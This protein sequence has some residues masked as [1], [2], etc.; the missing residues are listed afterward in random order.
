[1]KT[2]NTTIS[3]NR[4]ILSTLV[5]SVLIAFV[6]SKLFSANFISWDDGIVLLNNKDVHRFDLTAFFSRY[7]VGNYAPLSM[8]SF[9][10][11]WLIFKGNPM[12]HHA[13]SLLFHIVNSFLVF[14]F[15]NL[16][17][18][19]PLKAI[20]CA[21]VFCFHPLQVETVA[22]VSAKNNLV[23][24]LFFLLGVFYYTKFVIDNKQKYYFYT[25]LFFLLAVLSKPS[26]I[27]FP[28]LLI[29]MDYLLKTKPN[30]KSVLKNKIPFIIVAVTFGIV[31]IYTRTEDQ[32]INQN[33]DYNIHERIG[34]AGYAIS[35]YLYKFFLPI[36][37]SVIY[38]YP[39]NKLLS[40][41]I[42]YIS[43]ALF[44][45]GCFKLYKSSHKSVVFGLLFFVTNLLLVLQFIPFGEVLTADRYMYLP[46]IG[47]TFS[48]V[49]IFP[50]RKK[51]L[52]I[53]AFVLILI[54]GTLTFK[55]VNVWQNSTTLYSDILEKYPHSHIALN[56]LGAEYMVNKNY[57]KAMRLLNA[58]IYENKTYHKSYYNRGLLFAQT[59]RMLEALKDFNIA[60]ELKQYPKAYV[61]R[62]NAY[63]ELKDLPKAKRDAEFIL[64]I[65][66]NNP[67]ATFVLANCYSDLN[68]LDKAISLYTKSIAMND[69]EPSFYFKRAIALGKQQKFTECLNDLNACTN[70]NPNF[71][72]AYYWKGVAKVILK[73]NP[74]SD[75]EKALTLGYVVARD[76]YSK[77]CK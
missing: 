40:L 50:V 3:N 58:S 63:Y 10:I 47:L 7:Y 27:C 60:I 69:E 8:I 46:I 26:A 13:M 37:L 49:S 12:G 31:T 33:H 25:L 35:Q 28:L 55:R 72:E 29:L 67:N 75:L 1:M 24:S 23:Y 32:F 66:S 73:Q 36:N 62:A 17:L 64:S 48:L 71:A 59:G 68:Q 76:S 61:A 74:C 19:N 53:I 34:Y 51:Q 14:A 52:G 39:Q 18:K 70:I 65:D 9:A 57:D 41:S 6:Y 21:I 30:I 15:V 56:S 22:W 4:I 16:I 54:F 11:D 43:I 20:C 42:G 45:F 2:L 44:A 38:P 5:L 77:Y